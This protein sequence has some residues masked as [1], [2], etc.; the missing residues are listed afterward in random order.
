MRAVSGRSMRVLGMMSGTSADGID[1]ALARISGA[2]PAITPKFE[3]HHHVRFPVPVREAI[4]RLA[5]GATTTTAEIS[6]LNFLLGEE[7]A[8]AAH[9][10][11]QKMARTDAAD[12]A[13]WVAWADDFSSG[14]GGG[15]SRRRVASTLQIGEPSIIAERTG[16]TTI[17]DFRPADMA[18]GGQGAPLVP[19][20]DYLLYRDAR[21]GRVALNVGG[22]ANL[23][24][25]PAG[26]R[27]WPTICVRYWAREHGDRRNRRDRD[28]RARTL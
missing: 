12:F 18:A 17:A 19:F 28:T 15:I 4:L 27:A 26:A 3:R 20:V 9:C 25:I 14:R 23:T 21:I 8:R 5:N 13:D 16:V 22:I 2:P 7:F 10:G 24:V 1:V 11:L 6:Q